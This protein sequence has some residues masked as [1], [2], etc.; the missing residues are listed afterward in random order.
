MFTDPNRTLIFSESSNS[1]IIAAFA[2][3]LFRS[4]GRG[5]TTGTGAGAG[6]G[7]VAG[8]PGTIE[9]FI[10]VLRIGFVVIGVEL[11]DAMLFGATGAPL[12]MEPYPVRGTGPPEAGMGRPAIGLLN[13]SSC[14]VEI[15]CT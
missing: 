13:T 2:L 7:T 14:L 5:R 4:S 9:G 8:T 15:P 12:G 10:E 11:D 1:L 6:V 3:I